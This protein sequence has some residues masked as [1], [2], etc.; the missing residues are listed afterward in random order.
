MNFLENR[1]LPLL[2]EQF[3]HNGLEESYQQNVWVMA[4]SVA[5]YLLSP[6]PHDVSNRSPIPTH[7][8]RVVLRTTD[9]FG[10]N[11]YVDGTEIYLNVDEETNTAGLV[12]VDLWE[13]GSPIF[14]GGTIVDA[15]KWVRG[16]NE[17]FYIQLEDPFI[18]PVQHFFIDNN[19]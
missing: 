4:A 10:T 13:E 12:W 11:P 14:H 15:L 1:V 17:P 7:T 19:D 6:Y 3:S 18:T 2:H 8:L 5:P 9:E 16:L